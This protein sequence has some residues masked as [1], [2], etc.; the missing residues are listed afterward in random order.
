MK[1]ARRVI[2][3]VKRRLR[4]FA[5]PP[6]PARVDPARWNSPFDT[7][8]KKW[9]EVP[10][11]HDARQRTTD[12][13][14][15]PDHE[16]MALWR[17]S[18]EDITTGVQF[19][20]RGWYHALYRDSMRGKKVLDVGCGLAIDSITFAEHGA[21]VTFLDLAESNLAL[22][23]RVC[24]QLGLS[25]THFVLLENLASLQALE[26]EYDVIM[27]M[28]S[29]HHAPQSVIKP[30]VE[31]LLRHL[32]VGGRWLQLAYP[33]TRWINDGRPPFDRWVNTD[34]DNTP[35]VEWYDL[36][37]LLALLAPTRFEVVL[38][39][40]FHNSDFIWFDLMKVA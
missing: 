18:R 20:H 10:T 38:C 14:S 2:N 32:K 4:A 28:G 30:E 35:W 6:P 15:L 23:R 21:K 7:L 37:K 40:E 34:G 27:A 17:A 19:A 9:V 39:Q 29:L 25:D 13:A 31:I 36:P 11:R 22:V 24:G 12:L 1:F 5:P 26:A 8:R 3:G 33:Q 16:L